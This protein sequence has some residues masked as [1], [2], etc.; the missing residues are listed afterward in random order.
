MAGVK[1]RHHTNREIAVFWDN[2]LD[3]FDRETDKFITPNNEVVV[4]AVDS[5]DVTKNSSKMDKVEA[6]WNYV[7]DNVEYK[8][9]KKWKTPEET[10]DSGIGDC[11]DVTF[12]TSSMLLRLGVNNFMCTGDL[13]DK[14]DGSKELH[15]WNRVGDVLI[16]TTGAPEDMD[17]LKYSRVECVK[18]I[19]SENL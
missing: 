18:L 15:T 12:L 2:W 6:V 8:L 1:M 13:V 5:L 9:S 3:R 14:E 16:D 19:S 11:E 17:G 10:I 7:F 4:K